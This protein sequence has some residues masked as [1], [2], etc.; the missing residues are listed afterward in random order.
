VQ[1]DKGALWMALE[2]H[3]QEISCWD[4]RQF[5]HRTVKFETSRMYR[6]LI[7]DQQHLLVSLFQK[8]TG[9]REPTHY[10]VPPAGGGEAFDSFDDMLVAA[11]KR[12]ARKFVSNNDFSGPVVEPNGR[13][14]YAP[15]PSGSEQLRFYNGSQWVD[16]RGYNRVHETKEGLLVSNAKQYARYDNGALVP[17]AAGEAEQDLALW[18]F[19]GWQPYHPMVFAQSPRDYV[20]VDRSSRRILLPPQD[21]ADLLKPWKF[22]PGDERPNYLGEALVRGR[23]N[24]LWTSYGACPL[25]RLFS[26]HVLKSNFDDSPVAGQD[27]IT[28]NMFDDPSGNL[29]IHRGSGYG[30]RNSLFMK[31][32]RSFRLV[33]PILPVALGKTSI[34]D[35]TA[36]DAASSAP[37]PR[38]LWKVDDGPWNRGEQP[39]KVELK[40]DMPG[41]YRITVLGVGPQAELT[42]QPLEFSI[43]VGAGD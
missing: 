20:V 1:D 36:A 25:Y 3:P 14:W 7:D 41:R 6:L 29:W 11:V 26:G 24:S 15:Y 28:R 8:R 40:F 42:P 33:A 18:G 39:G 43:I 34:L 19:H 5:V 17:L 35:I 4:G 22:Q 2:S 27:Y 21:P 37:A 32:T 12:G 30:A 10:D 38:L 9:P 23:L 31:S 16:L 13:I